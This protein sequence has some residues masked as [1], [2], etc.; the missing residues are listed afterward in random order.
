M[1][2]A[3]SWLTPWLPKLRRH[4]SWSG[5][6]VNR[7]FPG[8]GGERLG[9]MGFIPWDVVAAAIITNPN[10]LFEGGTS[11]WKCFAVSMLGRTLSANETMCDGQHDFVN[12]A[13]V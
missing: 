10:S 4:A 3:S 1:G 5:R 8:A 12:V 13:I 9:S 2:N 11:E 6:L 7:L